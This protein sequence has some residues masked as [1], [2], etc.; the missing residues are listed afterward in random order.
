MS[1]ACLA[2]SAVATSTAA[3]T[4]WPSQWP[5]APSTMNF[6]SAT[7]EACELSGQESYSVWIA[8]TGRAGAVGRAEAGREAGDAALDLEAALLQQVGHQPG[9]LEL[10][11]AELAEI[12]DVV[13]GERDRL[14]VAVDIV[15]DE[16]LLGR[17]VVAAAHAF[18]L[19][20]SFVMPALV[21]S[22]PVSRLRKRDRSCTRTSGFP[23]AREERAI[24]ARYEMHQPM[25]F[26]RNANTLSQPSAACSGR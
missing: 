15:E 24:D 22:I 23:L 11:H 8:T 9:G 14:G 5:G 21:T 25:C 1:I 20:F 2:A 13:A 19:R 7:P 6:G 10:L 16:A 12:E 4:L 17:E 26:F 18:A 3:L